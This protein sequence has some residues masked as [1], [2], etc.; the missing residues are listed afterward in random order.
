MASGVGAQFNDEKDPL[1]NEDWI[2]VADQGGDKSKVRVYLAAPT[3]KADLELWL[4]DSIVTETSAYIAPSD[5]SVR[6]KR[7]ARLG[8]IVLEEEPLPIRSR[9]A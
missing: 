3:S 2:V 5:G 9:S 1:A 8:K 4:S 6:S 7:V